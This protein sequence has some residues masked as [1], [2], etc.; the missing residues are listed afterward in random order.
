MSD[1]RRAIGDMLT[2]GSDASWTPSGSAGSR[3]GESSGEGSLATEDFDSFVA[4]VRA[5]LYGIHRL[6]LQGCDTANDMIVDNNCHCVRMR[7]GGQGA[8][9]G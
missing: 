6:T 1:E 7:L 2:G 3:E 9:M 8:Q 5:T 4:P